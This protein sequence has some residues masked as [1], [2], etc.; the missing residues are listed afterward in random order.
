[1][2]TVAPDEL[3]SIGRD[4]F[5]G[6]G[7]PLESARQVANSLVDA[8]LAGHDSHGVIRVPSYVE[9]VRAGRVVA[10]AQPELVHET[11]S[12]GVVDGRWAFGQLTARTSM[13]IAIAKAK[14]SGVAAV[15]AHSCHH[16]GRL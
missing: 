14:E 9:L 12:I 8:N 13:A 15:S 4:I 7:V 2:L 1:M 3:R 5:V 10:T 16:I 11:A 6:A